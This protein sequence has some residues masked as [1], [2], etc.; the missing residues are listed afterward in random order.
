MTELVFVYGTL[1]RGQSNNRL[2]TDAQFISDYITGPDYTMHHNGFFPS[3]ITGGKTRIVGEVWEVTDRIMSSLD[4]LEGYPF[5]YNRTR[6][7]T[8][9]GK[10]WMYYRKP[11]EV[12]Q[13]PIVHDGDWVSAYAE[14]AAHRAFGNRVVRV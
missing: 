10:A 4:E 9:W 1:R 3:V 11:V 12:S 5:L 6:I 14:L 13:D 8:P 2:L 7:E